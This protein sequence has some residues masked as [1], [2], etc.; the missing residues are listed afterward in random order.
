MLVGDW[1]ETGMGFIFEQKHY[2]CKMK[3]ALY[4]GP[5]HWKLVLTGSKF[6]N[7]SKSR[8]APVE[9]E[10]LVMVFE[11]ESTKMFTLGNPNLMVGTNHKPLM[12]IKG[13]KIWKTSRT[14][15]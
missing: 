7:N 9:G 3:E 11:L 4:Y 6:N 8:Y 14:H 1:S 2:E 12:S 10:A 5:G 13:S 15:E